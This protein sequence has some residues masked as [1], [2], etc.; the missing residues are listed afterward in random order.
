[1]P[2]QS[3]FGPQL[4]RLEPTYVLRAKEHMS[5]HSLALGHADWSSSEDNP[6]DQQ[7]SGSTLA[8][9]PDATKGPK[10]SLAG[11]PFLTEAVLGAVSWAS[12]C[13]DAA[14]GSLCARNMRTV[15]EV[16][17]IRE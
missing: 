7:P 12:S 1:M 8:S 14:A 13:C 3:S 16:T 17:N 11:N 15:D 9:V 10:T 4:Y 5:H 6:F 2:D